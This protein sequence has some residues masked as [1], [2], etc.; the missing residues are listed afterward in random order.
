MTS[1][2]D[3]VNSSKEQ[4]AEK[5]LFVKLK[6]SKNN[7]VYDYVFRK[8]ILSLKPGIS[9]ATSPNDFFSFNSRELMTPYL[10]STL[11]SLFDSVSTIGGY[12]FNILEIGSGSGEPIE[13]FFAKEFSSRKERQKIDY[14]VNII[15]PNLQ[16]I[17]LYKERINK[18]Q[19]LIK[20][21]MSYN[22]KIQDYY[23]ESLSDEGRSQLPS[24]PKEVLNN[25]TIS[26]RMSQTLKARRELL[27]EKQI[28]S[29][30]QESEASSSSNSS[31]TTSHKTR[32]KVESYKM[33]TTYSTKT[34]A[35]MAAMGF[36]SELLKCNEESFDFRILE[37]VLDKLKSFALK[38]DDD[39][40]K[41]INLC[42]GKRF[43]EDVWMIE[44]PQIICVIHKEII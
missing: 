30:L 32:P 40:V 9:I 35:D 6:N 8:I 20:L 10:K 25:A 22:G 14:T 28:L 23:D 43:E 15:E 2:K 31:S 27:Y 33:N 29:T 19:R 13:W 41:E 5:Q 16:F 7:Q 44:H 18:Y 17:N 1:Y 24:L 38:D 37:F 36:A 11:N 4:E 39:S 3:I 34:L 26:S 42:R 21:G 12:E